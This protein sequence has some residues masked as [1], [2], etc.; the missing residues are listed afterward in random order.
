MRLLAQIVA[1][2][3]PQLFLPC[4]EFI[5]NT[6]PECD[7]LVLNNGRD[8]AEFPAE[9]FGRP[10]LFVSH[11]P[12]DVG[13]PC[14]VN[15][16]INVALTRGYDFFLKVDD[17]TTILT[18]DWYR[19][20]VSLMDM[21]PQ[22]GVIGPKILNPDQLTIQWANTRIG[23]SGFQFH[24]GWP[25]HDPEMSRVY[26]VCMVQTT[27]FFARVAHMRKVG[28]FDLLF[29]PSQYEDADYCARMWLNGF[30]CVYDGRIEVAH[31]ALSRTDD[32][33]RLLVARANAAAID[34]KYNDFLTF[35]RKLEQQIDGIGREIAMPQALA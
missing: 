17:D 21:D 26:R 35:G 11:L 2:R 16:G 32:P 12:I 10:R 7:F 4:I 20:C 29:S 6:C 19:K 23:A 15:F 27:F 30:S 31:L 22:I 9:V 5:L 8:P 25:R 33:N 28:Y 13:H 24:N 18:P 34:F 14:G 3:A 1:R